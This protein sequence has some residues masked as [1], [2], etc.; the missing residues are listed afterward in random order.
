[1]TVLLQ[2]GEQARQQSGSPVPWD[3]HPLEECRPVGA[4]IC[5]WFLRDRGARLR[6]LPL[7]DSQERFGPVAV[8][9]RPVLGAAALLGLGEA[10]LGVG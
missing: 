8:L 10:L 6:G 9:L 5:I 4:A 7:G 1:M 3:A 2:T